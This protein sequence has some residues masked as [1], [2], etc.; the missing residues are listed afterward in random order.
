MKNT[1]F[2]GIATAMITPFTPD[3]SAVNFEQY[4]RLIDR[5]LDAGINALVIAATTGEGPTPRTGNTRMSF[6]LP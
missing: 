6:P 3:G 1:V 5:Q 2:R 4:G